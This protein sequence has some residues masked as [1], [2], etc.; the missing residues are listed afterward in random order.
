MSDNEAEY[1]FQ[2]TSQN[3]NQWFRSSSG[4]TRHVRHKH[5]N[6]EI[7]INTGKSNYIEDFQIFMENTSTPQEGEKL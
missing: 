1:N 3:C 6:E 7:D 5:P 2:C 4:F